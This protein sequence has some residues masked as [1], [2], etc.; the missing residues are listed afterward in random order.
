M[1][2]A[3]DNVYDSRFDGWNSK[4]HFQGASTNVDGEGRFEMPFD[5]VYSSAFNGLR[6]SSHFKGGVTVAEDGPYRPPPR[7]LTSSRSRRLEPPPRAKF[8]GS[9][10]GRVSHLTN[11]IGRVDPQ[12]GAMLNRPDA[13]AAG[14]SA[15]PRAPLDLKSWSMAVTAGTAAEPAGHAAGDAPMRLG[16]SASQLLFQLPSAV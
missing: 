16:G 4:D 9:S 12:R 3:F 13:H 5:D 11:T 1:R 2:M 7:V 10:L 15:G 8:L 14:W 6:S